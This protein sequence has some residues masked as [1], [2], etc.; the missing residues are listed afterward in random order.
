MEPIRNTLLIPS[1]AEPYSPCGSSKAS[2]VCASSICAA[3]SRCKPR[4]SGPASPTISNSGFAYA[5]CRPHGFAPSPRNPGSPTFYGRIISLTPDAP[6]SQLAPQPQLDQGFF[7]ASESARSGAP[8]AVP[9]AAVYAR[10]AAGLLDLNVWT[11]RKRVE[12]LRYM[13]RDP[14]KRGLVQEPEHWLWSSFQLPI[15]RGGIGTGERV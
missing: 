10:L 12:K 1:K 11:E 2:W 8:T 4:C 3:W 15:W 6:H 5:N 14:V 13:H 7:T 9:A